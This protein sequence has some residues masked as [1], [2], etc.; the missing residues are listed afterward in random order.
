MSHSAESVNESHHREGK[1]EDCS[2]SC[3]VVPVNQTVCQSLDE[4]DFERGLWQA[5]IDNDVQRISY[6]ISYQKVHPDILDAY[7]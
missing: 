6:L 2:H 4:L 5:A 3:C 1:S 7:G